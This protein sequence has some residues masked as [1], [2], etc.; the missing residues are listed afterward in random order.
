MKIRFHETGDLN[1]SRYVKISLGS[2]AL[3]NNK[4]ND[5]YCFIWSVLTYLH[6]CDNDHPNRGSNY[7][8]FSNELNIDGFVFSNG[9]KCSV[10]RKFEKLNNLSTNIFELT[11][12]QD[13]NNWKHNLIPIEIGKN[14]SD[15]VFDLLIYKNH[16]ALIKKLNVVLG[17]HNKSFVYRRCLNSYTNEHTLTNHK[18]KCGE[19]NICTISTVSVT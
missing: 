19:D 5:K 7:L 12:Y 17:G 15:K 11:F 9:F 13:K 1:G 2:N 14:E 4:N 10:V 18:E 8:Q 3:I 16:Y 6:L